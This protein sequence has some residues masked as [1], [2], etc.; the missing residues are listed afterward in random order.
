MG[1]LGV[2]G[3]EGKM[4]TTGTKEGEAGK[5]MKRVFCYILGC[6]DNR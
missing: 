2:Q 3:G 5:R 6:S 1:E 4:C